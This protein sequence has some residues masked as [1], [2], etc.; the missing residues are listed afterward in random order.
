MRIAV[1]CEDDPV[2]GLGTWERTLPLLTERQLRP[3]GLWVCPAILSRH[4]GGEIRRWYLNTFGIYN[5]LKLGLFAVTAHATRLLGVLT[6]TRAASF[7][8]LARKHHIHFDRGATPNDQRFVAWLRDEQIDILV[9]LLSNIL[10]DEVLAAPRIGTINK[11]AAALPANRGLFPYFW[12]RLKGTPLGISFH[13]VIRGIDEGR[14]LVQ[15]RITDMAC[16]RSMVAF[17]CQV[18]QRYP[19]MLLDA[20][21]A[22]ADRCLL[23]HPHDVEAGY[24]GLPTPQDVRSFRKQKGKI[25]MWRDIIYASNL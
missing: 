11:H 9:I 16:Q 23:P 25:V 17:Y 13:E 8:A 18:F 21:A 15:E 7:P 6:G 4:K 22:L 20:I 5:F 1:I 2:W 3:V 10:K 24:F 19:E 12:A 14:L